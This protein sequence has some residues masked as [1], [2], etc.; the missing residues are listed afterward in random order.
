MGLVILKVTLVVFLA[1][2]VAAIVVT[3]IRRSRTVRFRQEPDRYLGT[4]GQMGVVPP[5][6]LSDWAC[7]TDAE[8]E[9][10]PP[11]ESTPPHFAGA[12]S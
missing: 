3:Y 4:L 5:T 2:G 1:G 9:Q 11:H 8:Q 6:P 7:W 10:E 12:V